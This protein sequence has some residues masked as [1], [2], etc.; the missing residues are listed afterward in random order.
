M[1]QLLGNPNCWILEQALV[2]T[3]YHLMEQYYTLLGF[4]CSKV[5]LVMSRSIPEYAK[6]L[7]HNSLGQGIH[8][9]P[10]R[11]REPIRFRSLCSIN[12]LNI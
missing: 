2:E 1:N 5:E 9:F 8:Y 12:S 10:I 4:T 11:F 7:L 3:N 6:T